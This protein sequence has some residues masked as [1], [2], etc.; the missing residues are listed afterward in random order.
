MNYLGCCY[1]NHENYDEAIKVF[2][3]LLAFRLWERPLFNKWRVYLKL[4]NYSEALACLNRALMVNPDESDVY[5]YLGVYYDKIGDY[6]TS[7]YYYEQAVR[8]EYSDAEYH[9]NLSVACFRTDDFDK[10][11]RLPLTM[12]SSHSEY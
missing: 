7:K 10:A 12:N 11:V 2:D 5:Y 4:G 6:E 3:E 9:L 1:I 8:I